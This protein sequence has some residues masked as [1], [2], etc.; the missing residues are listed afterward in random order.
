[1]ET[2]FEHTRFHIKSNF[3]TSLEKLENVNT[4][5]QLEMSAVAWS[6]QWL[7]PDDGHEVFN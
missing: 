3:P 2:I 5:L 7:L 4:E 1:V 6:G